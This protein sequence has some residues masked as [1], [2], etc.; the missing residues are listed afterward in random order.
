MNYQLQK[1]NETYFKRC[2]EE[3]HIM[4][5][6]NASRIILKII[7][8]NPYSLMNE[9]YHPILLLEISKKTNNDTLDKFRPMVVE[10]YLLELLM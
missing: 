3:R 7:Q 8:N 6:Q 1:M 10:K 9:E 2:C 4:I 5:N